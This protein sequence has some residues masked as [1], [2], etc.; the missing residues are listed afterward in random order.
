MKRSISSFC[1]KK[2]AQ[3]KKQTSLKNQ[4]L[5]HY[6]QNLKG[7]MR[8]GIW[9]PDP[10]RYLPFTDGVKKGNGGDLYFFVN[11]K[12]KYTSL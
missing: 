7:Q 5:S 4:Y 9:H 2:C 11:S 8:G 6:D 12:K 10:D 1:P 3:T